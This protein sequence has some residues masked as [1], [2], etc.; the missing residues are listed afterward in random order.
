MTPVGHCASHPSSLHSPEGRYWQCEYEWTVFVQVSAVPVPAFEPAPMPTAKRQCP[1]RTERTADRAELQCSGLHETSIK[2]DE[3]NN[4]RSLARINMQADCDASV[5][6]KDA[7]FNPKAR[8]TEPS[9]HKTSFMPHCFIAH[10]AGHVQANI[11]NIAS[12]P[13]AAATCK[14][15]EHCRAS[16]H[17]LRRQT[18]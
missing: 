15:N 18:R 2:P 5:G 16:R 6:A 4:P 12:L 1:R 17:H 10:C 11:T 7:N 14:S 13:T 9:D 8:S 3:S